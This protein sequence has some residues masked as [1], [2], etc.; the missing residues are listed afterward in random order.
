MKSV[1]KY[2]AACAVLIMILPIF[3]STMNSDEITNTDWVYRHTAWIDYYL[4]G[5]FRPALEYPPLFHLMMAPFVYFN[6]PM[7][8]FQFVF[9]IFT[10]CGLLY[11]LSR[12]DNVKFTLLSLML[13]ATSITFIEYSG[14]LMPQGLDWGL[15]FFMLVFYY[16]GKV[17]TVLALG[18]I[19]T[20]MHTIGI[21]FMLTLC[22]HAYLTKKDSWK[23][24]LL[25]TL[26]VIL[27]IFLYYFFTGTMNQLL[28]QYRWDFDAQ[29]TWD[30]QFL[31]PINFVIYSGFLTL[32]LFPYALYILAKKRFK[33]TESQLMFVL[34]TGSFIALWIGNFGIWRMISYQ[35][36][37]VALL[38]ASLV[39][40]KIE[41]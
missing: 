35:V 4:H 38:T 39:A 36:V 18:L 32:I 26:L 8:W 20:L 21:L 1:H 24:Y 40:E 34:L 31:E 37:P 14:A 5:D 28:L 19:M 29:A 10:A 13:L 25:F 7:K 33:L 30:A 15:F 11:Y 22:V 9:I 16:R 6:F 27:P 23:K 41:L 3:L 17:K 12:E 2:M